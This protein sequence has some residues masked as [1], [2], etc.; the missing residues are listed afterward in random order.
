MLD[1]YISTKDPLLNIQT[2]LIDPHI[3]T[4]KGGSIGMSRG[5]GRKGK[6]EVRLHTQFGACC[7]PYSH[8]SSGRVGL[9]LS[10]CDLEG[11]D[12]R[13]KIPA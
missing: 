2:L 13:S 1:N 12:G 10:H 9:Q 11:R 4:S 6:T 8:D 7:I 3:G 5:G